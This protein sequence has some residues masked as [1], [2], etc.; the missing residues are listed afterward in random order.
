MVSS[1]Y[2]RLHSPEWL[3]CSLHGPSMDRQLLVT[4]SGP[5]TVLELWSI[6]MTTS[7]TATIIVLFNRGRNGDTE[8]LGDLPRVTQLVQSR[9]EPRDGRPAPLPLLLTAVLCCPSRS[10]PSTFIFYS[11]SKSSAWSCPKCEPKS[12]LPQSSCQ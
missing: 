8:R 12:L 10:T 7:E 2:M 11:D 5:S 1:R 6:L 4:C 9:A 3:A